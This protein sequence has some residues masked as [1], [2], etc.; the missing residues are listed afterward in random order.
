MVDLHDSNEAME[1]FGI[2]DVDQYIEDR[3]PSIK[4]WL[5]YSRNL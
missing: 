4:G 2:K 3:I 1:K 5:D